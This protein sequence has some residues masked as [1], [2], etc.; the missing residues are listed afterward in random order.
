MK[1]PENVNS[2]TTYYE[3]TIWKYRNMQGRTLKTVYQDIATAARIFTSL[4]KTGRFYSVYARETTVYYRNAEN[5][6]STSGPIMKY[7]NNYD[8]ADF[9]QDMTKGA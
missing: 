8:F 4:V 6:L 9:I 1:A 3:I 2:K 7:E 5:E